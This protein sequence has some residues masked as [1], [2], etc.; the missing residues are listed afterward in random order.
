MV[1][2]TF[3]YYICN[4]QISELLQH[5]EKEETLFFWAVLISIPFDN[6]NT[7][8]LKMAYIC[9]RICLSYFDRKGML[10]IFQH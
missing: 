7:S 4:L 2:S 3:I 1:F 5:K 9:R 6:Y 8:K 10:Y